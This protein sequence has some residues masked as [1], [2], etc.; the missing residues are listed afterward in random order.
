MYATKNLKEGELILTIPGS[1]LLS[2]SGNSET[3]AMKA[4]DVLTNMHLSSTFNKTW[5]PYWDSLP[6]PEETFAPELL[7]DEQI[8]LLQHPHLVGGRRRGAAPLAPPTIS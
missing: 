5:G 3:S 7:S 2:F 1:L 4:R 6:P 8:Q